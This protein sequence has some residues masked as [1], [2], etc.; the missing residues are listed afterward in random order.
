MLGV[1]RE[2]FATSH[3][4]GDVTDP[5]LLKRCLDGADAVVHTAAL[6]APH[7]GIASDAEFERINVDG[8]AR[9]VDAARRAGVRRIVYTST[10][11]LYGH[12]IPA[13]GCA[14]IDE[15][16]TPL[17]RTVYHRTKLAAEALLEAA[18]GGGLSVR[19]IRMS[20]CFPEPAPVMAAYRLHRGIDLRDVADIHVV[21]LESG[22]AAFA[23]H[24]ASGATPFR[25]EDC[26]A[27]AHDAPAVITQRAP[28]L[29]AAFRERGWPLPS[30]ID[31]IYAPASRGRGGQARLGFEEVLAQLARRSIE[32]VPADAVVSDRE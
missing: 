11:A 25:P 26:P 32:V 12:A 30:T 14:W 28:T 1:D 3:V 4:I 15:T 10:T 17:P 23:R 8:V 20:R 2:P 16:V 29:A 6:H 24:I 21:A 13:G 31:R 18:A 22:G 19:V 27:L 5:E 9:L 7:V